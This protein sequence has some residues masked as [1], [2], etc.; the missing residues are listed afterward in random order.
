VSSDVSVF[1]LHPI[2]F[3]TACRWK[4]EGLTKLSCYSFETTEKSWQDAKSTCQ[5]KNGDLIIIE[6]QAENDFIKATLPDKTKSWWIGATDSRSEGYLE[7][8]DGSPLTF[9]YWNSGEP[10]NAFA[11]QDCALFYNIGHYNLK[12]G[13]SSCENTETYFVCEYEYAV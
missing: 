7:W 13:D 6:F 4:D 9:T 12:W 2:R 11:G 1:F 10:N 3:S 5:G 8:V